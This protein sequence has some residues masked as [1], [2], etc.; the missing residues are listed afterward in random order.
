ML[1]LGAGLYQHHSEQEQGALHLAMLAPDQRLLGA[2][3]EIRF[4]V[5]LAVQGGLC[6]WNGS[7]CSL[8]K[9]LA[10]CGYW[11]GSVGPV[12]SEQIL[13]RWWGSQPE[14]VQ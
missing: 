9:A 8:V 1:V 2:G 13:Q 12:R 5:K 14:Q 11:F 7:R 4:P 6:Y 10:W 3:D